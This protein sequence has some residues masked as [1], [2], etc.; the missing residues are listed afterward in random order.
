MCTEWLGRTKHNT[1]QEL[2]PL[3]FLEK[4][5]CFNWGLV[6]GL[7]QTY[8]PWEALWEAY[9]RGEGDSLDFTV[10]FHDLYRPNLRPYDPQEIKLIRQLCQAADADR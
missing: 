2:F 9:E 6:A 10:W 7:Y 1:V 5:G 4:I 8:E 3:F